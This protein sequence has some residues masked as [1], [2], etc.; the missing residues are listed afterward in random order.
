M[1]RRVLGQSSVLKYFRAVVAVET[2]HL[3]TARLAKV[4]ALAMSPLVIAIVQHRKMLLANQRR[5]ARVY[6][7]YRSVNRR[8][9]VFIIGLTRSLLTHLC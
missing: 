4:R 2:I 6:Y 9:E 7:K 5:L 8:I 1:S 3:S